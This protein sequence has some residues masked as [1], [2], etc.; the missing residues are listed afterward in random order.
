M[1]NPGYAYTLQRLK[2]QSWQENIVAPNG[3][4]DTAS[5]A[6]ATNWNLTTPKR[7]SDYRKSSNSN[8]YMKSWMKP[9]VVWKQQPEEGVMLRSAVS[10]PIKN[11]F[12]SS[13]A[14]TRS[15]HHPATGMSLNCT[16]PNYP[17]SSAS[18]C[19]SLNCNLALTSHN[20]PSGLAEGLGHLGHPPDDM[21]SGH[22]DTSDLLGY[23][24]EDMPSDPPDYH[25][26]HLGHLGL[27]G[28]LWSSQR[29]RPRTHRHPSPC[30]HRGGGIHIRHMDAH[31]GMTRFL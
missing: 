31:L 8:S 17:P 7:D 11:F 29:P 1:E 12:S 15:L 20:M 9:D 26:E 23:R 3:K 27:L 30:V 5:A 6:C 22:P 19:T 10:M 13:L 25:S 2:E 14:P 4:N 18:T 24:P 21:P 28:H 16:I